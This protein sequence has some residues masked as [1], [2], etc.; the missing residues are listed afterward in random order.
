MRAPGYV[1]VG[2][3][4]YAPGED[5]PDGLD[6]IEDTSGDEVDGQG[7]ALPNTK[8]GLVELAKSLGLDATG[9][10]AELSDRITAHQAE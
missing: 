6:N 5:L 1:L 9:T 7:D 8:E 2:E 3:R 4:L 10:K